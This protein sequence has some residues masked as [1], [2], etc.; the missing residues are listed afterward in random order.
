MSPQQTHELRIADDTVT[1]IY[2]SWERG[3]P[4]REWAALTV[5]AERAPGL[6]AVP[7]DRHEIEGRPAIVMTRLPGAPLGESPLTRRQLLALGHAVRRL[8]AAVP[9]DELTA[10]WP[11]RI[12]G[13]S[14]LLADLREWAAEDTDL[15]PCRDPELVERALAR[16]RSWLAATSTQPVL[17]RVL[18]L[19]DGNLGN[20]MWDGSTCRLVDFE[21]S[22]WSDAAYEIADL[23]EHI[24]FRSVSA[25]DPE[26]VGEACGIAPDEREAWVRW[27]R[28]FAC[29][30]LLMLLPSG[31]GFT[32]NPPGTTEDQARHLLQLL[33]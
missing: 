19:A 6:A 17:R 23:V 16:A 21:D 3:E 1:K 32:R 11:E 15:S 33:G 22:G 28:A 18:G 20:V 7:L 29:F 8:H 26:V 2:R 25:A 30:W 27:R 13:P 12:T 4:D 9:A 31:R 10:R 24:S 14:D 5:L